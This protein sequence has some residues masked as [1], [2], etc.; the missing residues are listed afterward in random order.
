MTIALLL[1]GISPERNISLISGRA[2]LKALRSMGHTVYPID[3]V[4]GL[5]TDEQIQNATAEPVTDEWLASA[6]PTAIARLVDIPQLREADLVY[7]VLHGKYGEDGYVQS[8]LDLQH[9]RYTGSGMLAS[10]LAMDKVMSK[11]LFQV[12]GIPTPH[13]VTV[14]PN[15]ATDIQVLTEIRK[16]LGSKMVVKP[17]DQGSTVGMTIVQDGVIDELSKAI[18][19]AGRYSD[20]ILI[21]QYIPGRELTV[22]VLGTDA[23]PVV[24]IVPHDGFYDYQHKYTKGQTEYFCPADISEEVR[25]HI[26]NLAV[27]AHQILD[28]KVIS[29]VDF[30]LTPDNVPVCLEVN[31]SPGFTELSLFPMAARE[32]GIEFGAL[33]E[34]IIRLSTEG[35]P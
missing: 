11:M 1:G 23:L 16:E 21:E 15:Q 7:T 29:R 17:N 10:A 25:D 20:T 12:A 6:D 13:W 18:E 5:L 32:A 34:E 9:I 35:K 2:V 31:T 26:M 33:C 4:V 14:T 28:C 24:E 30:R 8:V 3:P 27:A 19:V 22:S